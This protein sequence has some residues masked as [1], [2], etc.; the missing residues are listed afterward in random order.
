M[1]R[2]VLRVERI[3]VAQRQHIE[4]DIIEGGVEVLLTATFEELRLDFDFRNLRDGDGARLDE[5][6]VADVA[7]KDDLFLFHV[8]TMQMPKDTDVLRTVL[9]RKGDGQ[10]VAVR[11]RE[12]VVL[13]DEVKR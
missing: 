13:S 2:E 3:G 9:Q 4:I 1:G 6:A 10:R 8:L 12:Q 7:V 11:A 5:V